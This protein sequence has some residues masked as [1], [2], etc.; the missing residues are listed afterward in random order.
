MI[1][2]DTHCHLTFHPLHTDI[3]GVLDQARAKGVTRIIAPSYDIASWRAVADAAQYEGVFPAF[4]LHPWAANESLD[5][6]A[7]KNR[8]VERHAVAVGEIGLDFKVE[9]PG[10]DRQL[11]VFV[12]QL[13]VAQELGLPVLLH[14]RG[15]FAELLE[16]LN[17]ATPALTGVVHAY[18]RGPTLAAQFVQAGMHIGFGGAITRPKAHRARR[19]AATV[20]SNRLLLE[21]DAP[22]IGLD[23]VAP[24]DTEPHHVADIATALAALRDKPVETIARITTA[25]AEALF[26]LDGGIVQ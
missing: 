13:D 22:S 3:P 11:D 12:R 8:L 9:S 2:V 15:A 25:N 16:I 7:L 17:G 6:A 14:C 4:G 19:A 20:S 5:M 24:I 1:L 18:S 10:R 26:N 23:G 21:T